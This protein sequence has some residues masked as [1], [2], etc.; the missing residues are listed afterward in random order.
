MSKDPSPHSG[1]HTMH[2]KRQTAV[3][4]TTQSCVGK[5]S[6]RKKKG[7]RERE[8][9][10]LPKI[11]LC[12]RIQAIASSC[13]ALIAGPNRRG[14]ARCL[15]NTTRKSAGGILAPAPPRPPP[16]TIFYIGW[17]GV[18]WQPHCKTCRC[19]LE[20]D[21]QGTVFCFCCLRSVTAGGRKHHLCGVENLY[22]A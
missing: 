15:A 6:G 11:I 9:H 7:K 20:L 21:N 2:N 10:T 14:Q 8:T 5:G 18:G 17:I 3:L 13:C 4:E 1:C 19:L 16:P 12:I 22:S